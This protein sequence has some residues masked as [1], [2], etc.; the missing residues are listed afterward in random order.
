M[1]IAMCIAML[2]TTGLG[3]LTTTNQFIQIPGLLTP[4]P[5]VIKCWSSLTSILSCLTEVYGSFLLGQIGKIGPICCEAINEI[6]DNCWPKMFPLNP[7]FPSLLKNFCAAPLPLAIGARMFS[8]QK[9]LI[10]FPRFPV[11]VTE[12]KECWSPITSTEGCILEVYKS[13]TSGHITTSINPACCKHVPGIKDK[14]WHKMFPFNPFFPP[15]LKGTCSKVIAAAPT[16]TPT[17]KSD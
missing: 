13:L 10:P 8:G 1:L 17:P 2:V 15:L 7:F 12:I 5:D 6:N 16:P 3:E 4:I 9:P 14:C 11:N